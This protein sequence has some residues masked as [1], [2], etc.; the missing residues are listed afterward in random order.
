MAIKYTDKKT[1]VGAST[2]TRVTEGPLTMDKVRE[3]QRKGEILGTRE[4]HLLDAKKYGV[5]KE[6]S[7]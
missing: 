1:V 3:K 4:Q 2:S 6:S 7:D 5:L